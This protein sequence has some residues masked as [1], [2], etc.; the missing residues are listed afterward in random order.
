MIKKSGSGKIEFLGCMPKSSVSASHGTFI[1][2]LL[3]KSFIVTILK[4]FMSLDFLKLALLLIY[5]LNL[6]CVCLCIIIRFFYYC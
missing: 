5:E 3:T 1:F 6:L 4:L 2:N